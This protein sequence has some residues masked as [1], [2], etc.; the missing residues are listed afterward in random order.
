[1]NGEAIPSS[2]QRSLPDGTRLVDVVWLK[3]AGAY[4]N[5]NAATGL[6]TVKSHKDPGHGFYVRIGE[7]RVFVNKSNE[8]LVAF[9]G[10]RTLL[11][12][13][14]STGKLGHATPL[15]IFRATGKEK[16]HHSRLY[17][18][19]PMP[20]AVHVVG[21]IFVHG[22]QVTPAN[23]SSGCIRVPIHGS[24][25]AKWFY[26]WVDIGTPITIS[27]KWPKNVGPH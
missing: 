14:I 23:G 9:Q 17:H 7:K 25:P 18:D 19:A 1:M 2:R 8:T 11:R 20:W 21:N 6:L 4:V 27:G 12:T 15:G 16:M 13:R 22:F 24:N 3:H 26:S 10:R 5:R